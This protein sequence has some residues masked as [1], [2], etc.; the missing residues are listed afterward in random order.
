MNTSENNWFNTENEKI[1]NQEL[2]Q[3][4]NIAKDQVQMRGSNIEGNQGRLK[5]NEEKSDRRKYLTS[6][7]MHQMPKGFVGI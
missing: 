1:K 5:Q 2:A 4:H 7:Q 6:S 3:G